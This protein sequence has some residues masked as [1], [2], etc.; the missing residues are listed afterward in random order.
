MPLARTGK[1]YFRELQRRPS[2]RLVSEDC[3]GIF[4]IFVIFPKMNSVFL[5]KPFQAAHS[6]RRN[7]DNMFVFVFVHNAPSPSE[8]AK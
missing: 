4:K 5:R 7:V 8:L 3:H 6:A 2:G 1:I